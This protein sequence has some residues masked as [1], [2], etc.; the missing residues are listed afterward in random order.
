MQS[1]IKALLATHPNPGAL[2][3]A[4]LQEVEKHTARALALPV[5]DELCER[6]E[7]LARRALHDMPAAQDAGDQ[8]AGS[9]PAMAPRSQ[10]GN[11]RATLSFTLPR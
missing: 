11:G 3:A 6:I 9:S 4:F 1:E 5:P 7:A 10:D 2:R 8:A